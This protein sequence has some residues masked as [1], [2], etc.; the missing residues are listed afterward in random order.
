MSAQGENKFTSFKD[1]VVELDGVQ[2]FATS[3]SLSIST[4]LERDVR[5]EGFSKPLAGALINAPT[6][7]PTDGVKGTFSVDFV[8]AE[9]HF[10]IDTDGENKIE[11]IFKISKDMPPELTRIG[12]VGNFR[13]FNAGIKSFSF[14]MRPF[15]LVKASAEYEIFGSIVNVPTKPL[16]YIG[17]NENVN[18]AEGLKSFGTVTARGI[19]LATSR[20]YEIE[21]ISAVYNIQAK[22]RYNYTMR[23]NEHPISRFIPGAIMPYRVSFEEITKTISMKSNKVIPLMNEAGVLQDSYDD[24]NLE[25]LEVELSLFEARD[26]DSNGTSKNLANFKCAGNITSQSLEVSDGSYLSGDFEVMQVIK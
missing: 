22:R 24:L 19:N 6:L 13:F 17:M 26:L 10:S 15:S 16:P 2:I 21:L 12:R 14:E 23:A 18:P 7:V 1:C 8:I 5:L 11:N 4:S 20:E 3:A 9:E 25:A